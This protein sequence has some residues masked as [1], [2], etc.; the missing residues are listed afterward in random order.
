MSQRAI[1]WAALLLASAGVMRAA[2]NSGRKIPATTV[3]N[4]P[5]LP[6]NDKKAS[7]NPVRDSVFL[8]GPED[9]LDVTV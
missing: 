9:V 8:I 3:K 7:L 2:Q 4:A 1:S 6:A 5:V